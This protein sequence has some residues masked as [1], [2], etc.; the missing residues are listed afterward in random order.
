MKNQLT[1]IIFNIFQK[2]LFTE[3]NLVN[4][5][6]DEKNLIEKRLKKP[7]SNDKL[8]LQEMSSSYHKDHKT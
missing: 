6:N 1:K 2:N 4:S 5:Q 3:K 8:A 7:E